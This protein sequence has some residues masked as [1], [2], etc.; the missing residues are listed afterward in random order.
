MDVPT[1]GRCGAGEQ[2]PRKSGLIAT[3]IL[4]TEAQQQKYTRELTDALVGDRDGIVVRA[5]GTAMVN[6]QVTQQSQ[7]DLL[8]LEAIVVPLSFLVLIW[9]F[10]ALTAAL[11]VGVGVMAILGSLRCCAP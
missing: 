2:R 8:T 4:G 10:G 7:R 9:V 6:L 1:R 11:P 5:G 3:G